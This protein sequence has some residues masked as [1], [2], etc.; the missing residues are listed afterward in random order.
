MSTRDPLAVSCPICG[1]E[2]RALSSCQ[3]C[4]EFVGLTLARTPLADAADQLDGIVTEY[5][6]TYECEQ[7]NGATYVPTES[8][9]GL[10]EDAIMG[11]LADDAFLAALD[12]WRDLVRRSTAGQAIEHVKEAAQ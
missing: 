7:D 5:V 9:R 6:D 11:L 1:A 2:A 10:I 3:G 8:E 12:H 4:G